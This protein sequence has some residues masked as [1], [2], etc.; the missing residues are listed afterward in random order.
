MTGIMYEET[1]EPIL[2]QELGVSVYVAYLKP[3]IMYV[4][5][6][7]TYLMTGIRYVTLYNTPYDRR[8]ALGRENA[9]ELNTFCSKNN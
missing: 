7:T 3:G 8:I 5:T 2:F 1:S 9:N 6:F 4:S